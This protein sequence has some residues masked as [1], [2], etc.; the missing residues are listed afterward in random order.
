MAKTII[1]GCILLEP[2]VFSDERGT[3]FVSYEKSQLESL[4]DHPISFVQDNHSVS[5][6][7][8][9]RGLHFQTGNHAQAKLVR[10][11]RGAV[12]DVVVD[13]RKES[14]TFGK[15]FK[16]ELSAQ[17]KKILFVPRGLAHGFLALEDQTEFVYKCDNYYNKSSE[18]GIIFNDP[19]LNIDWEYPIDKMI[20]SEKDLNLP[21][22][23][24]I[25]I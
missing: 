18:E 5:R 17:N 8:V 3:F 7:G 15:H 19:S 1:E 2:K 6:K 11:T 21:N 14:P 22:F 25:K 13:L 4:L 10:V 20:I 16:T 24:D 23:T 12:I 9:L